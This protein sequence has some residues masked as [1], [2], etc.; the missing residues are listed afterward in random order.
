[1]MYRVRHLTT[2][3]YNEPV[4]VGHHMTHLVPRALPWQTCR[5][6]TLK[7]RPQ[8][9][10]PDREGIDFFGNVVRFFTLTDPHR[11]LSVEAISRIERSARPAPDAQTTTS[12][13]A[14]LDRLDA[15]LTPDLL[16]A[17][18]FRFDSPLVPLS[19]RLADYGRI[20]FPSPDVPVLVGALDL[21][22]RIHRDFTY[23]P[24]ATTVAT[25]LADVLET[26]RGVCQD[27]AHL[28]IGC[29]RSLGLAARYVS[30]YL[31]T[32]PPPGR[33]RLTGSDASHA[34]LALYVP[35]TGW[36]D[37]DPTN[38][39]IPDTEHITTAWGRDYDDVS[40]LK[41]VVL[42]GGEQSLKVAVDVEP[43][44]I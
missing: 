34:W 18:Q 5:R 12:F 21:M 20:S 1:M 11:A 32:R 37:L 40:P 29:L 25:P 2:C 4:L 30:G 17:V 3:Q 6:A 44:E 15:T 10:G 23:D 42:G 31:M 24:T 13:A 16:D 33:A 22:H 14:T 7:I 35:E 41:G 26:R 36:V 28:T 38:D 39:R 19:R 8:P 27:F 43:F 9:S